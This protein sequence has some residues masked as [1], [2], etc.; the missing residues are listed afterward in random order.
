MPQVFLVMHA[1]VP[2]RARLPFRWAAG[3]AFLLN[4]IA[5][6][7]FHYSMPFGATSSVIA[8]H[9]VG[10]LLLQIARL[11]LHMPAYRYVDDYFCGERCMCVLCPL[12]LGTLLGLLCRPSTMQH[13]M[14]CFAR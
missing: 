8:W 9:R 4:G 13:G 7:A 3:V 12:E 14:E 10:D 1:R 5:Q 2:H 6:I 11:I